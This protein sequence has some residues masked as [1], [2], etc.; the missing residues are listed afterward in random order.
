LAVKNN[1]F[2]LASKYSSTYYREYASGYFEAA[3]L[4]LFFSLKLMTKAIFR[5]A[6]KRKDLLF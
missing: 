6:L 1:D 5:S 3:A 4:S 2:V